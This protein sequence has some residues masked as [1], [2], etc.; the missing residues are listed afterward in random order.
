ML[1]VIAGNATS[2]PVSTR[3][4]DNNF[5]LSVTGLVKNSFDG[6]WSVEFSPDGI[7]WLPHEDLTDIATNK[8]G[9][10]YFQMPY[11]RVVTKESTMGSV[12]V[13]MFG[14]I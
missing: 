13:H 5:K 4:N 2:D 10:V 9:N 14:S 7:E 6:K 3:F 12:H 8:T 1:I 11:L